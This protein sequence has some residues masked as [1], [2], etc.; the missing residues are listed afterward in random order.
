MPNAPEV[1]VIPEEEP[2]IVSQ[3]PGGAWSAMINLQGEWVQLGYF[4]ARE[5]AEETIAEC[6]K[7]G[8]GQ[9][10]QASA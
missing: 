9:A 8:P 10:P 2:W 5:D 7:P 4:G 1:P 3:E 6:M